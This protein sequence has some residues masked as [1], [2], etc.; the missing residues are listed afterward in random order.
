MKKISAKKQRKLR[1]EIDKI[2]NKHLRK[3]R[4][5]SS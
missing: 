1:K 2:Y 5:S 3:P 4:R